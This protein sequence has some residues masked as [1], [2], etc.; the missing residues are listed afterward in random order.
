M[1]KVLFMSYIIRRKVKSA[2]Y[3]YEGKSYRNKQGKPPKTAQTT[4]HKSDSISADKRAAQRAAQT[5]EPHR[6][7]SFLI[8]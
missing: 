7:P 4:D 8:G 6:E 2:I 1:K 3:V 5:K